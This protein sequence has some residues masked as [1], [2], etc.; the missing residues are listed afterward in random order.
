MTKLVGLIVVCSPRYL[1]ISLLVLYFVCE[2]ARVGKH[3]LRLKLM[4]KRLSRRVQHEVEERKKM[5]LRQKMTRTIRS[6]EGPHR[7]NLRHIPP[8]KRTNGLLM[9]DPLRSHS[10]WALDGLRP[11]SSDR[12]R[13]TSPPRNIDELRIMSS[14]RSMD[15]S[16][17]GRL[18]G[19]D[20]SDPSRS[21][22]P[23]AIT[24]R[25]TLDADKP[26]RELLPASGGA[27]RSSYMVET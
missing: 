8:T 26:V 15:A 17:T 13:R 19:G 21:K 11:E 14:A 1:L 9:M 12:G 22:H 4:R 18:V 20:V 5:E 2:G 7:G 23:T 16:R 24:M 27:L 3:D 25:S 10:S 6:P